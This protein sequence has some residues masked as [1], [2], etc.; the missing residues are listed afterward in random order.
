M[1]AEVSRFSDCLVLVSR[2]PALAGPGGFIAG[3]LGAT[4][5]HDGLREISCFPSHLGKQKTAAVIAR[6]TLRS[7]K[8]TGAPLELLHFICSDN[9]NT[10]SGRHAGV[11]KQLCELVEADTGSG[12]WLI[13]RIP[14]LSHIGH[15]SGL[16]ALRSLGPL[17]RAPGLLLSHRKRRDDEVM[18]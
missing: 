13:T 12:H 7:V 5:P 15:N 10:M 8:A 17:T 11:H 3:H 6:E 1:P 14:C 18:K 2:T 16:Q 4:R 9:D